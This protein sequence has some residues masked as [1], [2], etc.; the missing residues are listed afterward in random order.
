M[1][2]YFS[3]LKISLHQSLI[4][5]SEPTVLGGFLGERF[6]T[7]LARRALS[8]ILPTAISATLFLD[9]IPSDLPTTYTGAILKPDHQYNI[10]A[11]PISPPLSITDSKCFASTALEHCS[12]VP[13]CYDMH[14]HQTGSNK[15]FIDRSLTSSIPIY[16]YWGQVGYL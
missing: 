16:R 8:S 3:K 9:L 6:P 4:T 11:P 1:L 2:P 13:Q 14:A 12:Q 10:P 7:G 15:L 5:K